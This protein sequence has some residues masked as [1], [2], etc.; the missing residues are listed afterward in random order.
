VSIFQT[1]K[2]SVEPLRLLIIGKPKYG[3]TEIVS[4]LPSSCIID[5][6]HGTEYINHNAV[7]D[8]SS[9]G[10]ND[11]GELLNNTFTFGVI[12]T[13][14]SMEEYLAKEVTQEHNA[15][16]SASEKIKSLEAIPYGKGHGDLRTKVKNHMNFIFQNFDR[17]IILGHSKDKNINDSSLVSDLALIGK[18]SFLIPS[19]VDAIAHMKIDG[20][21]RYL[22][23]VQDDN[24]TT[25]GSRC[26]HLSGKEILISERL[27]DGTI[28]TYWENIYPE[29]LGGK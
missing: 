27:E 18:N 25:S 22:V 7:V 23:F 11:W 10:K 17:T 14:T 9:L 20:N 24:N 1:K 29:T 21:K 12:D 13:V 28:K 3:K 6:E 16:V 5:Y 8:V 26:K 4:K 15:G 2:A 19:R